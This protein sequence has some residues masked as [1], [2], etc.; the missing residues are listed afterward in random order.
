ML[1]IVLGSANSWQTKQLLVHKTLTITK[2]CAHISPEYMQ[3]VA[4]KLDTAFKGVL[5][6]AV[7]S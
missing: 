2:R 1:D 4:G 7:A 5:P 6:G 3:N